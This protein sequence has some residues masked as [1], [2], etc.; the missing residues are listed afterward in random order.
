MSSE[1]HSL[2]EV[3]NFITL[4]H[5]A[6]GKN[7]FVDL[8]VSCEDLIFALLVSITIS[9]IFTLGTRNAL[10]IPK[11]FQNFLESI[12]EG[13]RTVVFSIIGPHGEPYI[14]FIGT[15]FIYTLTMNLFG[16]VPLLKAPSSSLNIT[17]AQSICVFILVQYLN[18][19]NFGIT[20]FMYH[21]A[22]SPKDLVG[23]LIAPLLFPI[24]LLTQ[25]SRPLTLALRLFG[26]MFGEHV[27]VGYF[28]FIGAGILP[29]IGL[30]FQTPLLFWGLLTSLMQA[31]V[32][33]LL[34]TVYIMLSLPHDNE[35]ALV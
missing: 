5:S 13:L 21:L 18:I 31:M 2:H 4:I 33:A 8:L 15:I 26:N 22:G 34:T 32:F 24:E 35:E 3:P 25:I 14:P 23:W 11:R 9:V 20:G 16:L 27:L 1:A 30:P 28:A 6:F 10:L 19:K 17:I 7:W 29:W 12:A